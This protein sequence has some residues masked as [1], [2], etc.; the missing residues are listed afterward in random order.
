M[1]NENPA[2]DICGPTLFW[3]S[4]RC[5]DGAT[6]DGY[7][8]APARQVKGGVNKGCA[9]PT[10]DHGIACCSEFATTDNKAVIATKRAQANAKYTV[11]RG[12]HGF[13]SYGD[14]SEFPCER[15][16]GSCQPDRYIAESGHRSCLG[17]DICL[18]GA[19][20]KYGMPEGSNVCAPQY[21]V[22]QIS[23]MPTKMIKGQPSTFVF[24]SRG[25]MVVPERRAIVRIVKGSNPGCMGVWDYSADVAADSGALQTQAGWRERPAGHPQPDTCHGNRPCTDSL[26]GGATEPY[27]VWRDVVL[28]Q[29]LVLSSVG[30]EEPVHHVCLCDAELDCAE[31]ENWHDLGTLMLEPAA[32]Y[33][34]QMPPNDMMMIT[35]DGDLLE[36]Y[37][38][39]DVLRIRE[40]NPP[41]GGQ[42][43]TDDSIHPYGRGSESLFELC[44]QKC[45]ANDLCRGFSITT[46]PV[47]QTWMHA[48]WKPA[49]L[50]TKCALK[51]EK[52]KVREV[53]RA[54]GTVSTYRYYFQKKVSA[55]C[56]RPMQQLA[57]LPAGRRT[58]LPACPRALGV[59]LPHQCMPTLSKASHHCIP[60]HSSLLTRPSPHVITSGRVQ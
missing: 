31:K 38:Y 7:W 8:V 44:S 49:L 14:N 23:F 40:K 33:F 47:D 51:G 60:S 6:G 20:P 42:A 32:D 43:A 17:T 11:A 58:Y 34:P 54:D 39:N 52:V 12:Y 16:D 59:S 41:T 9:R 53:G 48:E 3:T 50:L 46:G 37:T 22:G 36:T 27:L 4:S 35:V 55:C 10:E 21:H 18:V 25:D 56:P 13:C 24:T 1:I 19:G 30:W 26:P 28:D 29:G 15:Y 2:W 57:C 5:P 45:M